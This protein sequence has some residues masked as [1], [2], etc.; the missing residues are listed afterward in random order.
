LTHGLS[1]R[2][3]DGPVVAAVGDVV[4]LHRSDGAGDTFVFTQYLSK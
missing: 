4:P 1:G 3:L 2:Q